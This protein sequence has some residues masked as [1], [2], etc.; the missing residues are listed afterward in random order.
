MMKHGEFELITKEEL[1]S[2]DVLKEKVLYSD[3]FEGMTKDE[4]ERIY[5]YCKLHA[6]SK[7]CRENLQQIRYA[8]AKIYFGW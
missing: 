4:Q 7:A 6:M 8:V 1:T 3:E 2:L 5:H